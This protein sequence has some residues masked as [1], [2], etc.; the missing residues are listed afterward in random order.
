[1]TPSLS[2]APATHPSYLVWPTDVV[3]GGNTQEQALN[4]ASLKCLKEPYLVD[5]SLILQVETGSVIESLAQ[6]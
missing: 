4:A 5:L 3:I 2:S 6:T 1:M